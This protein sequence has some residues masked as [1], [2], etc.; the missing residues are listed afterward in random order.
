MWKVIPS[1]N[2]RAG[3][4]IVD[5]RGLALARC[6][7]RFAKTIEEIFEGL[8]KINARIGVT[9]GERPEDDKRINEVETILDQLL[10]RFV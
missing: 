7:D 9:S 10:Q 4:L 6:T 8:L 1:P 3:A 5:S 2:E